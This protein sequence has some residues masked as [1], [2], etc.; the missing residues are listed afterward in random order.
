MKGILSKLSAH[1]DKLLAILSLL[2]LVVSLVYLA[3]QVGMVNAREKEFT[4]MLS[5]IKIEH[6]DAPAVETDEFEVARNEIRN[7]LT[8]DY[9]SWTN[10]HM[11]VLEKRVTCVDCT[12][13]IPWD[14]KVCTFCLFPQPQDLIDRDDYD[15]DGDGITDQ[16]EKK[17]GL[18]P[19]DPSDALEDLDG[20]DYS[21]LAEYKAGTSLIDKESFPPPEAELYVQKITANPFKLRFKSVMRMPGGDIKFALNLQMGRG[22]IKTYFAKLEE[23][24]EGFTLS[25]YEEKTEMRV[26]SAYGPKPR[27]IDVSEL[28]LTRGDKSIVLIKGKDVQHDEYMVTFWFKLEDSTFDKEKG[29]EFALKGKKYELKSIDSTLSSVVIVRLDDGAL[30]SIHKYD[31]AAGKNNE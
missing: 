31:D 15:G 10:I 4:R 21:N 18:N 14:A 28:T 11:F 12:L 17:Y 25:K 3:V 1:Y 20:D 23:V 5:Q 29:Q 30:I 7:P 13:P 8:I 26:I 24:V 6:K 22:M 16:V 9:S 27:E 19:R 2:A